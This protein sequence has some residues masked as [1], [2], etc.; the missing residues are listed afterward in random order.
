M[1]RILQSSLLALTALAAPVL[2]APSAQAQEICMHHD[3]L[4]SFLADRHS[5]VPVGRGLTAD[6][7]LLEVFSSERGS[8]TIVLTRPTKVSCVYASGEY[9]LDVPPPEDKATGPAS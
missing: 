4:A 6:G 3:N 7:R 9:W 2:A 5:E 1:L 8:W